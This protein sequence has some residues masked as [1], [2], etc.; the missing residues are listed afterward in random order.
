M[1]LWAK[2]WMMSPLKSWKRDNSP[3]MQVPI[4][5]FSMSVFPWCGRVKRTI[6]S[7]YSKYQSTDILSLVLLVNLRLCSG[8]FLVFLWHLRNVL[9][10]SQSCQKSSN[11]DI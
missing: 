5:L 3:H 4:R 1:L 11:N 10:A 8:V 6:M 9:V 2:I 7:N